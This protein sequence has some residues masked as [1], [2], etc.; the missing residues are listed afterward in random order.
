MSFVT[1]TTGTVKPNFLESEVGLVLKTREIPQTLGEDDN[2]RKIVPAGTIFPTDDTYATGIVFENVDVTA[3]NMPGSVMVA[4]RVLE[5]GL[6]VDTEAKKS[7][8]AA[9]IVFVTA[10]TITRP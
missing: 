2:G 10:P 3:G 8:A 7:L 5:D 9:G 6:T 1:N 4:G